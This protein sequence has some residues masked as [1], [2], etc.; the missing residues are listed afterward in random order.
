MEIDVLVWIGGNFHTPHICRKED[1]AKIA[2]A[3]VIKE[4]FKPMK[5]E[6]A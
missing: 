6:A 3:H 2:G 5:A 4:I 1:R